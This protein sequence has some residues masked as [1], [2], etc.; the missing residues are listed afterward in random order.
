[1]RSLIF[2]C[3]AAFLSACN[4]SSSKKEPK[5]GMDDTARMNNPAKDTLP[6]VVIAPVKITAAQLPA[7]I[8]F[9]GKLFEAWQWND[10]SGENILVNSFE[11]PYR[12]KNKKKV[13]NEDEEWSAG[14]HASHYVKKDGSYQLQWQEDDSI[15]DCGFDITCAFIKGSTTVTDIDKNGMAE[16]TIQYRLACRSDVSPAEMKLIMHEDAARYYLQGLCWIKS[17]EEDRFTVT[18]TN[19]NLETLP[20]YKKT[21]E[22]YMKTFGRYETEKGFSGA[23][24]EFLSYARKQWMKFVIESFE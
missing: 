15:K 24:P 18:E 20:G 17:S 23:P 2:V 1:M 12:N 6:P 19:A 9:K 8:K 3:L 5:Q 13:E 16:T 14:L 4:S 10:R 11:E 21:D 22:E 7:S